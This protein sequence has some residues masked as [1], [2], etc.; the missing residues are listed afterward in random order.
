M[1]PIPQTIVV[2][3]PNTLEK[4]LFTLDFNFV[5][6]FGYLDLKKND[7]TRET[8]LKERLSTVDLLKLTSLNGATTK[9]FILDTRHK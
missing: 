3:Y 4:Y 8:L 9:G 6:V 5:K 1:F 2:K 7:K